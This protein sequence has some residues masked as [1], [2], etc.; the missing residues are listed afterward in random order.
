MYKNYTIYGLH[1]QSEIS[2]PGL[3]ETFPRVSKDID[4]H[5]SWGIFPDSIQK[6]LFED[7]ESH[8]ISPWSDSKGHP[9]MI[10][11]SLANNSFFHFHYA[12][13]VDFIINK[14]TTKVWCSWVKDLA[15]SYVTLYFL[16][17]ILGFILRQ[18]GISCLHASCVAVEEKAFAI[19]GPSGAGKSTTAAALAI[20]GYSIVSDDVLPLVATSTE[21]QALPSYPRLRIWSPTVKALFGKPDAKPL[22]APKCGKRYLD[23]ANSSYLF[24]QDPIS[25]YAIYI[26]NQRSQDKETPLIE[27][28]ISKAKSLLILSANIYGYGLL[29]RH[30]RA[31][32][33]KF[34]SHIVTQ[35]PIRIIKPNADIAKLPDLCD[36]VIEDFQAL[37]HEQ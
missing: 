37:N 17:P 7:K 28:F 4:V 31:Q 32:E 8:Y 10:I 13:G 34:L 14:A 12:E 30:L 20:R 25:I 11:S 21:V 35:I 3:R 1:I 18:R 33:F 15:I 22:L 24:R 5:V 2:I 29:D 27:S 19:L 9:R 26:I 23:L 16:N 6:L 36:A